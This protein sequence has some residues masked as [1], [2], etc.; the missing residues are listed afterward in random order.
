MLP[1][2]L[3]KHANLYLESDPDF[4]IKCIKML[5]V[6]DLNGGSNDLIDAFEFYRRWKNGL[7]EVGFNI[8]S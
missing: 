2:M 7:A 6:D 4:V 5:P 3:I 8:R 1:A